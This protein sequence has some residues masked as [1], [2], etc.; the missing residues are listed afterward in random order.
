MRHGRAAL[1]GR[2]PVNGFLFG[3][4]GKRVQ[5]SVHV[6]HPSKASGGEQVGLAWLILGLTVPH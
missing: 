1:K 6:K 4:Q 5:E 2:L 3:N